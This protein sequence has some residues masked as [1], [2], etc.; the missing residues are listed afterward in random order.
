[1]SVSGSLG[2]FTFDK[3]TF[4]VANDADVSRA[5]GFYE[6]EGIPTSGDPNIKLTKRIEI[7]EG[8]DLVVDG[9]E[10]EILRD[11]LNSIKPLGISY[12]DAA[13]NNYT[14]DGH[15]TSTGDVT[16]DAKVTVTVIPAKNAGW[17][18]TV[19]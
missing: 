5:L 19:V 16:Q 7:A 6:K 12:T 9:A 13:G 15:I 14:C 4:R 18:A 8:F 10:R 2:N 3:T 11:G 17:T 1:M